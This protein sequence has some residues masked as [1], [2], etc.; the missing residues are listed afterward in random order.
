MLRPYQ[1]RAVDQLE[2]G[3]LLVSPTGTGKSVML[4]EIARREADAGGL[5]LAVA[6]RHEL[7]HQLSNTFRSAWLTPEINVL[8]RS[9]QELRM[10]PPV[11]GVTLLLWDEAHHC[12]GDDWARLRTEQYPRARLV[13]ATATPERGDGRAL[14]IFKRIVQ[15]ISVRQAIEA[16]YLVAPTVLRPER[17]LA[18]GELAQ[19]PVDAYLE[20]ARGTK[21]IA[22]FPNVQLAV[23]AACRFRETVPAAA[24]WG[25]MP[26]KDR[27]AVIQR[28]QRGELLV[29]TSVNVLTEGFD[30]PETE[31]C[32]LARGFGTSGGYLQ[33]V[34]R[35]LRPAAGKHRALVLDLR[36]ASHD[37]GDPDDDRSFHLEGKG[38]RRPGDDTDVRFCPVCGAPVASSECKQC[39]HAGEMKLRRPR[40]LGLPLERFAHIRKDDDDARA[41][42]LARW[43]GE[44]R[45]KGW[46]EGRALHRFKGAYGDWPTRSLV[47][48]A[49]ALTS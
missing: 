44:C 16:G 20:H 21:A 17:A 29:L 13:G 4:A 46:K 11:E 2:D 6:H 5:V 31:T 39:G 3:D 41:K 23:E 26:A 33:A 43:M 22:F 1:Q 18:P 32:I 15:T 27:L 9:I 8:V 10:Q 40:V 24:I 36:G 25:D 42:R 38:I 28:F 34:G 48:R 49:R 37:H 30:V 45:A 7:I 35:V 14:S 19:D 12:M 47:D